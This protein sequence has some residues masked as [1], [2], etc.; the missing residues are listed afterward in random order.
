[1]V[2]AMAGGDFCW[3]GHPIH[4][5][6]ALEL[7]PRR[8]N[9]AR[10]VRRVVA[11]E[12]QLQPALGRTCRVAGIGVLHQLLVDGLRQRLVIKLPEMAG[13]MLVDVVLHRAAIE[14]VGLERLQGL[15]H[16]V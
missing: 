5:G 9:R 13:Q 15:V 14:R 11:D 3:V 2:D 6:R 10:K 7:F 4:A 1:M 8:C 16:L 12:L